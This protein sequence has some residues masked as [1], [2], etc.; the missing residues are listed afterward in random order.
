[1]LQSRSFCKLLGAVIASWSSHHPVA[2]PAELQPL[3]CLTGLTNLSLLNGTNLGDLTELRH[4]QYLSSLSLY[5]FSELASKVVNF[6]NL[7]SLRLTDCQDEIW[8]FS[9]CSSLTTLSVS[10][11][12]D[13]LKQIVLPRGPTVM[14]QTLKLLSS[15]L[16][17]A[18]TFVM[19]NIGMATQLTKVEFM[20]AYPSN[21]RGGEWPLYLPNLRKLELIGLSCDLPSSLT[22]CSSLQSLVVINHEQDT[23]PLWMS[24]MTQLSLLRIRSRKLEQFPEHILQLSQL[25]SL[26]VTSKPGVALPESLLNCA[27]W[28]NL[29]YMRIDVGMESV[30]LE[31]QLIMLQLRTSLES[32]NVDC[33][34]SYD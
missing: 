28:P 32:Y 12:G 26:T 25:R 1:V 27:H 8:D 7:Q 22:S 14:L 10:G 33:N 17:P 34:L 4:L 18:K 30:S 5:K 23:S 16:K 15:S 2:A 24:S 31:S 20:F 29:T 19:T 11:S 13:D 9:P 3:T 21:F 6:T